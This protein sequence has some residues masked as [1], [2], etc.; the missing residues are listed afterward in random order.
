MPSITIKICY[1]LM[2]VGAIAARRIQEKASD[3]IKKT[4]SDQNLYRKTGRNVNYSFFLS[5]K[6]CI[7]V[8]EI[9]C[10]IHNTYVSG[11][12]YVDKAVEMMW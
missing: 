8:A 4:S 12:A 2:K 5:S 7:S 9:G 3:K 10:F 1:F 6:L 11:F